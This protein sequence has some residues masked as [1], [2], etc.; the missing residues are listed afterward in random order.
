MNQSAYCPRDPDAFFRDL[1]ALSSEVEADRQ[2]RDVDHARRIEWAGRIASLIGFAAAPLGSI[3]SPC[4]VSRSARALHWIIIAH[5]VLHRGFDAYPATPA[6]FRSARFARGWRRWIDWCDW[7]PVKAW[8]KEHNAMHHFR[9]GEAFDPDVQTNLA[10]LST[11]RCPCTVKYLVVMLIAMI[12][13]WGYYGPNVVQVARRTGRSPT[14]YAPLSPA[15]WNPLHPVGRRVWLESWGPH[16]LVR[17]VAMPSLFA[18]TFGSTAG[19][20]ALLN[21]I[22]AELIT[23]LHAFFDDR[24]EPRGRQ[25][26]AF[27]IRAVQ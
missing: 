11:M 6:R 1:D 21:L 7:I 16:F 17:F 12:W 3:Q 5:H 19:V 15:T 20:A 22:A 25:R 18:L 10:W 9:L 26:S 23:S 24:P 27:R 8:Q 13:K 4:S 2:A 14:P